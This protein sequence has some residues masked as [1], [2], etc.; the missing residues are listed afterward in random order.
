MTTKIFLNFTV[1]VLRLLTDCGFIVLR[2][3]TDN[4]D[5]NTA[6][7]KKI[8]NVPLKNYINHPFL[9]QIPIFLSFDFCHGIKI[10]CNMFLQRDM[11]SFSGL[12]TSEYLKTT[13]QYITKK[14]LHPSNYEKMDVLRAIQ[15]FSPAVTTSLKYAKEAGDERFRNVDGTI[16]YM[17]HMYF[18]FQIHNVSDRYHHIRVLDCTIRSN[19]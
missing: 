1:H 16:N 2:L 15:I 4:P 7:F 9:P 14:H 17:E 5:F 12:I 3:L 18:L 10:S 6:L 8:S 11:S 19:F 13:L